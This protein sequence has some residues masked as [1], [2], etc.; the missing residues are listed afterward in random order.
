MYKNIINSL[1]VIMVLIG[2]S[3][4]AYAGGSPPQ[5]FQELKATA[6]YISSNIEEVE[7]AGQPSFWGD[8]MCYNWSAVADYIAYYFM[9]EGMFRAA[10]TQAITANT[11]AIKYALKTGENLNMVPT[12]K[13]NKLKA[14]Q[15]LALMDQWH[16]QFVDFYYTLG[17]QNRNYWCSAEQICLATP[18]PQY[19]KVT[20]F[21][22]AVSG[23][24]VPGYHRH[25]LR[26]SLLVSGG[27]EQYEE[28]G[29]L[30]QVRTTVMMT[31]D[32]Y[33]LLLNCSLEHDGFTVTHES[34]L[35]FVPGNGY[36]E[37]T[38]NVQNDTYLPNGTTNTFDLYCDITQPLEAYSYILVGFVPSLGTAPGDAIVVTGTNTAELLL[39]EPNDMEITQVLAN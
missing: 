17:W 1:F 27:D 25:L 6:N 16:A 5:T 36:A 21:K 13:M 23:L 9:Y 20:V 37:L 38:F 12:Y 18:E 15:R 11:W 30:E 10:A 7:T 22:N 32:A 35:S 26:F 19:S 8:D 2:V 14:Q 39:V 24:L 31:G 34:T 3:G 33:G 29:L 4:R 28:D